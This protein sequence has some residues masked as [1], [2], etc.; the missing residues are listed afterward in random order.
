[1]TNHVTRRAIR[2][3]EVPSSNLGAPIDETAKAPHERGFLL[4]GRER[5]SAPESTARESVWA[6][7]RHNLHLASSFI[8]GYVQAPLGIYSR[9]ELLDRH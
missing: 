9:S 2:V 5:R 6:Q 1:M 4:G 8:R 3:G 7:R